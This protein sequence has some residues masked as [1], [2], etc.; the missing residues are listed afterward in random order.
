M[1]RPRLR[2]APPTRPYLVDGVAALYEVRGYTR[3][4]FPAAP[5]AFQR[6]GPALPRL[7]EHY[8]AVHGRS[9]AFAPSP[10]AQVANDVV[11]LHVAEVEEEVLAASPSV[12]YFCML[13]DFSNVTLDLSIRYWRNGTSASLS[14]AQGP[15]LALKRGEVYAVGTGFV[16]L[17]LDSVA[18]GADITH[19]EVTLVVDQAPYLLGRYVVSR[20]C[21]DHVAHIAYDNGLGGIDV[22]RLQGQQE[23]GSESTVD[24]LR[25]A[26][27]SS[28]LGAVPAAVVEGPRSHQQVIEGST[29]FVSTQR[30]ELLAHALP[31]RAWLLARG[32]FLPGWLERADAAYFISEQPS[33]MASLSLRFR[34]A[35]TT[36]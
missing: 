22:V 25:T 3:A 36:A 8:L 34:L 18:G 6:L 1:S 28:A 24:Y 35:S 15:P 19:Y 10:L 23:W 13:Y 20:E 7:K 33:D 12:R 11:V 5:Q 4:G 32:Q 2:S 14:L 31:G 9:P 30:A 27:S 29:G 16:Q 26:P 21:P 17:A